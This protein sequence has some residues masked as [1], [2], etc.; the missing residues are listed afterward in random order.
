MSSPASGV[1]EDEV[2]DEDESPP[3]VVLPS[4]P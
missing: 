1:V 2:E 3:L 4:P